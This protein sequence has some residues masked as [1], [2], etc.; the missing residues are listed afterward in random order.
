MRKSLAPVVQS[1]MAARLGWPVVAYRAS[2]AAVNAYTIA[3]SQ[4]LQSEGFRVNTT[5]PGLVS[6]KINDFSEEGK[7]LKEGALSLQRFTLLDKDGPTG[8][9]LDWEEKEMPW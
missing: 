2:K 7:S 4:E 6:T 1:H 3:L 5:A 8:K 9:F